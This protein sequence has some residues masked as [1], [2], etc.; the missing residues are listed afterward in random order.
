LAVTFGF[1]WALGGLLF[2]LG[3]QTH[4]AIRTGLMVIYM[5]GPALGAIAAQRAAG[6]R[7]FSPLSVRLKPNR[8]WLVA[9]MLPFALQPVAIAFALLMP[10]VQWSSDMAGF[11]E[12]LAQTL[13]ADQVQKAK[14]QIDA[15]PRGLYW[16]LMAVNPLI[17]GVTINA[18]A[19][20]G[21]ELGWRGW[22]HR[23][24]QG[25]GFWR[26]QLV[27]GGAW[28]A[29][30]APLILQGHNYPQHPVI[31]VAMMT[32]FCVLLAPA[33]DL[34]RMRG[35]SVWAAAICH[36]TVNATAGFS[37]IFLRGG[38]DLTVGFTG[39]AGLLTLAALNA[40][41]LLADRARGGALLA[42][43]QP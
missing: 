37:I 19:A 17:A 43:S 39:L 25:L 32:A 16:V 11:I 27:V 3:P 8:W 18:V 12:R 10:D 2:A 36:G 21:E 14:E 30:H 5:F 9:W 42:V 38:N 31:G 22:L 13:P 41:L 4:V 33:M 6:E 28:G 35:A 23:H 29:W 7:L 15:M 40:G 26:R 1:S 24:L 20:F 34:V